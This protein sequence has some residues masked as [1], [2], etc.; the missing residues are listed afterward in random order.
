[1]TLLWS[2]FIYFPPKKV[3]WMLGSQENMFK[4]CSLWCE[5]KKGDIKRKIIGDYIYYVSSTLI[6]YC[7]YGVATKFTHL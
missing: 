5:K 6:H 3:V 1:M 7:T 4:R 2:I